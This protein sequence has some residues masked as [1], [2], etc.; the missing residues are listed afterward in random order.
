MKWLTL[1]NQL[2]CNVLLGNCGSWHSCG[3][4]PSQVPP[5][6]HQWRPSAPNMATALPTGSGNDPRDVT[7]SFE[8]VTWPPKCPGPNQIEP[9]WDISPIYEGT[10]NALVTENT[11]PRWGIHGLDL[12]WNILKMP[13]QI[14]IWGIL[15]PCQ[16][17]ELIIT[18]LG[19]FL[20]SFWGAGGY[21]VLL[22]GTAAIGSTTAFSLVA[23]VIVA[24]KFI[25]INMHAKFPSKELH[26]NKMMFQGYS[27]HLSEVLMSW[28][29]VWAAHLM[30]NV[31]S[32]R[33]VRRKTDFCFHEV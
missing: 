24:S 25:Q 9:Q 19:L 7:R 13:D 8:G 12:A 33:S 27:L 11:D 21:A 20:G 10:A 5:D 29:M 28:L 1:I 23:Q 17:F 32:F 16:H 3:C 4:H 2:Q 14:G 18:F 30:C 15:R 26:C 22:G 6:E 31:K